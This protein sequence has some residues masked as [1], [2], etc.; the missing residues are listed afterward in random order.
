MTAELSIF[1][2]NHVSCEDK[3][4][5]SGPLHKMFAKPPFQILA[6]DK[7]PQIQSFWRTKSNGYLKM[8]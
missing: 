2:R 1:N 7:Q 5:V 4:L 6:R 8:E 3:Y